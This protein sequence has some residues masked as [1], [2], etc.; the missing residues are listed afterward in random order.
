MILS[1]LEKAIRVLN[2]F[3]DKPELGVT[4]IGQILGLNKSN[5]FNI[6]STYEKMGFVEHNKQSQ[7]YR[8]SF[9]VLELSH[10][11]LERI[12]IRNAAYPYMKELASVTG[13]NVY[14]AI[15]QGDCALYLDAASPTQHTYER[16]LS[17]ETAPLYCTGIGKAMLA[18]LPEERLPQHLPETMTA[19]TDNTITDRQKL[20]REL[21]AIRQRGYS[22]DNM[23]HE[24]G[25]KCVGVPVLDRNGL[26]I[27]ALSISGPSLRFSEETIPRYAEMLKQLVGKIE[28]ILLAVLESYR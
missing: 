19:Y 7:K 21:E 3:K 16:S 2:T 27:A 20:L 26:A 15:L 24:F 9:G 28:T 13:E 17:G 14:L 12:G 4:E 18:Y 11:L 25:I 8:L 22:I 5:V 10:A 6:L 23:E 1:S